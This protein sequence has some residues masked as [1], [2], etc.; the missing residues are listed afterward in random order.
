[1][2]SRVGFA[3]AAFILLIAAGLRFWDLSTLPPG[4]NANEI[5]NVRIAESVKVGRIEV[6]YNLTPLGA[7]GGREGLYNIAVAAV[8]TITGGGLIGYRIFSV[9]AGLISLSLV[10]AAGMRLY[11][12]LAGVAAMALLAVSMFPVLLSRE[13]TSETLLPLLTSAALLLL[14][15]AL[16]VYHRNVQREPS[17]LIYAGLG[18][19]L[20]LGFYIHPGNFL[21]TLFSMLFIAYMVLSPEMLSRRTI[22]YISFAILLL[23]I[24]SMPYLLSSIRLPGLEGAG[25]VFGDYTIAELSPLQALWDGIKGLFFI[26]DMNPVY[27]LP[28]RPMFD[29]VSGVFILLGLITALRSARRPRYLLPLIAFF[30]L[31][32]IAFLNLQSPNFLRY[33]S[34]LPI[35]ALLFGLGIA[36]LYRGLYGRSRQIVWLGLVSLFIFNIG[37]TVRDLFT[38]WPQQSEVQTAYDAR[39]MRLAHHIDLTAQQVPTVVCTRSVFSAPPRPELSDTQLMLVMLHRKNA[40]VR[41]VDCGTGMIFT[42]GGERQQ[43]IMTNPN[44]LNNM[45]PY[46]RRWLQSGTLQQEPDFPPDSVIVLDVTEELAAKIGLFTTTAPVHYAPEVSPNEEQINPPVRFGGNI[47]FLGYEPDITEFY[48]PGSIVTSINFWRVDGSL[49]PDMRLF[50]HILSDPANIIAQTDT[51]SFLPGQMRERDVFIQIM[52]LVL[53]RSATGGEYSMSIGAYQDSD[54]MR[55]VVLDESNIPRGTRLFL[56]ERPITLRRPASE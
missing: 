17:T 51:R 11:G 6:F 9:F 26:G 21:I 43:I 47:T 23:I 10:Y 28:G 4:L 36:A 45:H 13:V 27:N 34:L 41:Y 3:L 31:S 40:P 1:M 42:N 14:V 16:P 48:T 55:M 25:R 56:D 7:E 22:S 52:F 8:S 12:P 37:W 29:L 24:L 38:L 49:P 35:Q 5:I 18:V 44:T 20:G 33:A 53:P 15:K 50:T 46:L 30:I 54:R 39:I 2:S 32:P 19:M